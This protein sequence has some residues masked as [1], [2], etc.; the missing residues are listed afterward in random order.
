M[1]GKGTKRSSYRL[2]PEI[3]DKL[4][5]LADHL[6][7]D[8]STMLRKLIETAF[9]NTQAGSAKKNSKNSSKVS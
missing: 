9:Y 5:W 3:K 4:R 6:G 1:P 2:S 7:Y 8:E